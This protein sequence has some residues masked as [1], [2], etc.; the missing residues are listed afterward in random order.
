MEIKD[1]IIENA[2][3]ADY[4]INTS[5]KFKNGGRSVSRIVSID[6][7]IEELKEKAADFDGEIY[8]E[9]VLEYIPSILKDLGKIE[10]DCENT[11]FKYDL[12]NPENAFSER[13]SQ[14]PNYEPREN[15]VHTLE[16]GLP[17]LCVEAG[18][19]WE[20]P[21]VLFVYYDFKTQ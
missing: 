17:Y 9:V 4:H 3:K 14:Y 1:I 5:G 20:Y 10:F 16:N 21:V 18:G 11:E 7:F 6:E 19:D 12:D 8:P 2:K 13:E 15:Y